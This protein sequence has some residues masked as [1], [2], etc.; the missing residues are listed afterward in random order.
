MTII[1][2]LTDVFNKS[3]ETYQQSTWWDYALLYCLN[4]KAEWNICVKWTLRKKVYQSVFPFPCHGSNNT[5]LSVQVGQTRIRGWFRSVMKRNLY[6]RALEGICILCSNLTPRSP[7][8]ASQHSINLWKQV[9]FHVLFVC[10]FF[11]LFFSNHL[12]LPLSPPPF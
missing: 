6:Y 1:V 11:H 2:F 10:F 7:P 12:D 3:K 5:Q 9:I 8:G 4:V